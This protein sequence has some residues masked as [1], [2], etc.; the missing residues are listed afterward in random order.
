M[1]S[2]GVLA[3]LI[4]DIGGGESI[5]EK[6]FDAIIP[7]SEYLSAF[8]FALLFL[9]YLW[10]LFRIMV[11]GEG[12]QET[13]LQ[14]TARTFVAGVMIAFSR[15]IVH[16]VQWF[17]SSLYEALLTA[18]AVEVVTADA[19][20]GTGFIK[21]FLQDFSVVNAGA[22]LLANIIILIFFLLHLFYLTF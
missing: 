22:Q 7:L 18:E 9:I 15:D 2:E 8:A 16:L 21:K 12:P 1:F 20:A 13:P 11:A 3:V 6:M 14:L 17:F 19:G 4:P 10:Q 5:F